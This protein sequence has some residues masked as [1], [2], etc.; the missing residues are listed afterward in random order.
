LL[1]LSP[2]SPDLDP[3]EQVFSKLKH[4]MRKAAERTKEAVWRKIG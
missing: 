3:I 1:F 4:L 2:Y